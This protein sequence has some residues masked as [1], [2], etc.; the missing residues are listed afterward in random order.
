MCKLYIHGFILE[1]V[2]KFNVGPFLEDIQLR[3]FVSFMLN[4]MKWDLSFTT[5]EENQEACPVKI[6]VEHFHANAIIR[7]HKKF[8]DKHDCARWS[9]KQKIGALSL[10]PD[11]FLSIRTRPSKHARKDGCCHP[12][13]SKPGSL[14]GP[15]TSLGKLTEYQGMLAL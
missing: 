13:R 5:F 2:Q 3:E 15:L 12:L 11:R 10:V 7:D 1:I 6:R 4:Q 14:L 8:L 9:R